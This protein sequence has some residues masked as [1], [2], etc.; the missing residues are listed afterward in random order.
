VVYSGSVYDLSQP[1][2]LGLRRG[3]VMRA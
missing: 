2:P 1:R 3:L